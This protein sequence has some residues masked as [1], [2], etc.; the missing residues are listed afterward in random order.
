MTRSGS[1]NVLGRHTPAAFCTALGIAASLIVASGTDAGNRETRP[2]NV[3]VILVDD[4]GRADIGSPPSSISEWRPGLR[5]VRKQPI[6]FPPPESDRRIVGHDDVAMAGF[7]YTPHIER[8]LERGIV[9]DQYLTH[10]LCSPSRAGLLTGRHYTRVGSGPRTEGTLRIDVPNVARQL[11][12]RG[13]ATAAFGKW[14]NG[15]P[16][17]PADGN[18]S[19]VDG[20]DNTDPANDQFDNFKH[21]PWGTGVNAYGF[22]EWQGFFG[23]ATD[24]FNRMSRWHNDICWWTDKHYTP[25]VSGH[26]VNIVAAAATDF[27]VRH[28][29][30]P[31]FC[32]VSMPAPHSPIQILKSDL[33]SLATR[34]PGVW[35]RVRKLASPTTGRLIEEVEE[36][37]CDK[38]KEFDH[39]V[40]DPDGDFF[41]LLVRSAL[42]Y[43]MDRGVGE[44]LAS[45]DS[46]GLSQNTIVWFMSD[47]GGTGDRSSYPLRDDKG[48]LY[49]GGIRAPAA[50]WWPG[51]LD[52]L[53]SAYDERNVYPHL[54]QYLDVYPTTMAMVGH[55]ILTSDLE[56]RDGFAALLERTPTHP[57]ENNTFISFNH[58][59]AVVRSEYWKLLYNEAGSRQR[60]ELYD[61]ARDPGEKVDV[62]EAH[63]EIM[64]SMIEDLHSFMSREHLAMSYFPP[65]AAWIGS[66]EP[67]P[68]GDIL[69][70][71]ASQTGPIDNGKSCGLFVKFAT[72]GIKDYD[73]DQLES[74]DLF[75]FDMFVASDSDQ[76]SGFFVTPGRGSTPVFDKDS[77]VTADGKLMIERV[78]PRERWLRI[79]TGLGE[80]APLNQA[81]D[82]IALRAKQSGSYHFFLDNVTIRR[83][84]GSIKAIIWASRNDTLRLRYRY[85]GRM[86][87]TWKAVAEASGFP[88]SQVSIQ[89][90]D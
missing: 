53:T 85:C 24:Y 21:I 84:D 74:S 60:I 72:A 26:T 9:L 40:L 77:G 65:M 22:D 89:V 70:I 20:L 27:F 50:V 86:Y 83:H 39:T 57:P 51:T 30:S 3:V 76:A 42:I 1:T 56:G 10:T 47:N 46:L 28:R 90:V 52:A 73:I 82:Y 31:F 34:F 18:G 55:P 78:W 44:I 2:P 23:G 12:S 32:L 15:Y 64:T 68:D 69:E 59:W 38:G 80:V 87:N 33:E 13:Y 16:N 54:F 17:F 71:H 62:K 5:R 8:L 41:Y 11:Q 75:S 88:F 67:R 81:V 63:P 66:D 7:R 4:L 61:L 29:D 49:E 45:I 79:A 43:A 6:E 48:S 36:L 58:E 19:M 35:R 37:R 14:H 25:G